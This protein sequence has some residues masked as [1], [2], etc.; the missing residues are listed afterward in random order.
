MSLKSLCHIPAIS[1]L[2]RDGIDDFLP[3]TTDLIPAI[4]NETLE[5]VPRK[6]SA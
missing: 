5:E 2:L 1:L 6:L 3:K 4:Q